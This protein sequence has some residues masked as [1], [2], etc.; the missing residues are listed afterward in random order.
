MSARYLERSL[1]TAKI[2]LLPIMTIKLMLWQVETIEML[3]STK[4]NII[5]PLPPTPRL[6]NTDILDT[7]RADRAVYHG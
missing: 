4:G 7:T 6:R 1:A 3:C 5:S 2:F